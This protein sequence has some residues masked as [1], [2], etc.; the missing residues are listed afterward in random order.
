[1]E[2]L[3]FLENALQK[4]NSENLENKKGDKENIITNNE[5]K[6]ENDENKKE[7][8]ENKIEN[9]E[10]KIESKEN[11]NIDFF[12]RNA[13][14]NVENLAKNKKKKI[15]ENLDLT[16]STSMVEKEDLNDDI[17]YRTISTEYSSCKSIV[18]DIV[19][20]S[21]PY[22][23]YLGQLN[24]KKL[25]ENEPKRESFCEAFF[26]ASFPYK[27]GQVIENSND[28]FPALCMHEDCSKLNAMKPEIILRYPLEDIKNLDFF[29]ICHPTF[30][31]F[32]KCK[33]SFTFFI[34]DSIKVMSEY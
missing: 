13:S 19:L 15:Q 33:A 14:L 9:N 27:N 21:M 8:D 18:P 4:K 10:N 1:M 29:F 7:N 32:F 20:D 30:E 28:T 12:K 6:K 24:Q 34:I 2:K 31:I 26:L 5:N 23:Q 25:K 11:K 16:A 22:D 3:N 17:S